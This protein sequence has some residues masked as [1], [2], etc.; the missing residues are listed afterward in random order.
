MR[1]LTLKNK[2]MNKDDIKGNFEWGDKPTGD[3]F[4]ELIDF[5]SQ[6]NIITEEFDIDETN[7]ITLDSPTVVSITS[8]ID[9]LETINCESDIVFWLKNDTEE[10]LII[11]DSGNIDFNDV[12]AVGD[13][14]QLQIVADVVSKSLWQRKFELL[15][16]MS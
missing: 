3:E 5:T 1:V 15:I 16:S 12:L 4:A 2:D 10:E 13:F 11:V 14:I 8:V 7:K 6:N 9:E